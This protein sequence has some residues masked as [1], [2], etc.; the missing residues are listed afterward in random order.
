SSSMHIDSQ[1]LP[2]HSVSFFLSKSRLSSLWD[3][4][5]VSPPE[6][7]LET[8]SAARHTHSVS[9]SLSKSRLSSLWD[10]AV[11]SPPDLPVETLGPHAPITTVL[12]YTYST[13][14]P[15]LA[16]ICNIYYC[17]HQNVFLFL[18]SLPL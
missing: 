5:V 8:L 17:H 18:L 10:A 14:Y 15:M 11:V 13:P 9:F 3:A 16:F 7:S 2:T 1:T 12:P 6:L 4:A